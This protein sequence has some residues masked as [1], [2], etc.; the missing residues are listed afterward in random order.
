MCRAASLDAHLRM[1]PTFLRLRRSVPID[2]DHLYVV[3]TSTVVIAIA[4]RLAT[5]LLLGLPARFADRVLW[6]RRA[7]LSLSSTSDLCKQQQQQQQQR[8]V[9]YFRFL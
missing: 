8:P 4:M 5:R 7:A 6:Q 2:I 9:I 1:T 3:I